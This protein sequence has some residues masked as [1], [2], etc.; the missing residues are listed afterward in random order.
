MSVELGVLG[1]IVHKL[2]R[3]TATP[4]PDAPFSEIGPLC[5]AL[6][7]DRRPLLPPGGGR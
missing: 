7:A 1:A 2:A 4:A 3:L 5:A 6:S